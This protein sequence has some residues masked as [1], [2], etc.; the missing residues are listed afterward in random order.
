M[1]CSISSIHQFE[2]SFWI[3]NLTDLTGK[4]ILFFLYFKG[5]KYSATMLKYHIKQIGKD[6]FLGLGFF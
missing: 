5:Q 4:A 3:F 6:V 1:S 2:L